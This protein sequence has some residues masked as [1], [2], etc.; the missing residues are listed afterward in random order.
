MC[1]IRVACLKQG[2]KINVSSLIQIKI[3]SKITKTNCIEIISNIIRVLIRVP[4]GL[5]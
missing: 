1:I 3:K 2:E 5:L 4:T